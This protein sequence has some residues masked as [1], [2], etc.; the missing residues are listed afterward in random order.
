[1][2]SAC[3]DPICATLQVFNCEYLNPSMLAFSKSNVRLISFFAPEHIGAMDPAGLE[4]A[5]GRL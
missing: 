5:T 2:M 4:P 3:Y 1:M